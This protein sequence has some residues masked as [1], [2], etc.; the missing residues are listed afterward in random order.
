MT[1]SYSPTWQTLCQRH[2]LDE[3]KCACSKVISDRDR[4]YAALLAG[5]GQLMSDIDARS[6]QAESV[7]PL[8]Q[9]P[10][11]KDSDSNPAS[12]GRA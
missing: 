1:S 9:A 8:S 3:D 12:T 6:T 4:R 10:G 2:D 5:F 7:E 11:A